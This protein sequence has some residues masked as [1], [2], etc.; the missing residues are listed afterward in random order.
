MQYISKIKAESVSKWARKLNDNQLGKKN[1][2]FRLAPED[3][4]YQLTGYRHNALTPF[5]MNQKN[6]PLIISSKIVDNDGFFWLGG[7][8]VDLKLR[9]SV[10]ELIK[11]YT[12]YVYIVNIDNYWI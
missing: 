2:H 8:H 12:D 5:L 10:E 11:K 4:T 9:I 1:F 3:V 6:I 7:G